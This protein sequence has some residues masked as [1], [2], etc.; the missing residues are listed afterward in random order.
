M[1]HKHPGIIKKSQLSQVWHT[2]LHVLI[3]QSHKGYHLFEYLFVLSINEID[4]FHFS[5]TM[6]ENSKQTSKQ[7][8]Q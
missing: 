5:V 7:G 3:Q 1:C 2:E 6:K 8:S 4:R